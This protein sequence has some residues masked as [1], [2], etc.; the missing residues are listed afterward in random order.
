MLHRSPVDI[1]WEIILA[2]PSGTDEIELRTIFSEGEEDYMLHLGF[3]ALHK[4]AVGLYQIDIAD[5]IRN[6]PQDFVNKV[7]NLGRTPVSY[8]ASRN[9]IANLTALLDGGADISI[10]DH[11]LVLP[12]H[13]AASIGNAAALEKLLAAG[14]AVDAVTSKGHS[15]LHEA[16]AAG[17]VDSVRLLL[18]HGAQC[19]TA[20]ALGRQ[21]LYFA[22]TLGHPEMV[23][24]LVQHGADVNAK[25]F[26][27]STAL[28]EAF[29]LRRDDIARALVSF[30]AN[31]DCI[32]GFTD[33][34][35][36][37]V[38]DC[39]CRALKEELQRLETAARACPLPDSTDSDI[40][41]D[42]L[43]QL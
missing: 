14:A 1:A 10:G 8:A 33:C 36:H 20:D 16:V 38:D 4:A 28:M 32:R 40:F 17:S 7:D 24:I 41:E 26:N 22:A 15:A 11:L 43:E 37:T 39:T 27:N 18:E 6:H 13:N 42:A 19:D 5:Y 2:N 25:R 29:Y 23:P 12:I 31:V 3:T 30:G 9:E 35:S 21:P 34:M